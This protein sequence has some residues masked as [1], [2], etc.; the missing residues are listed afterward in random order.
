[1][2]GLRFPAVQTSALLSLLGMGLF[3]W[4][5]VPPV[6]AS[7]TVSLAVEGPG[8]ETVYLSLR[9]PGWLRAGASEKIELRVARADTG[10]G[11][12]RWLTA[13]DLHAAG[14]LVSPA[15][16]QGS[17]IGPSEQVDYRWQVEARTGEGVTLEMSL[18]VQMEETD[19][20]R[21]VWAEASDLPVM[22]YLGMDTATARLAGGLTVTVAAISLA[23]S[24]RLSHFPVEPE[25]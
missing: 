10:R 3:A 18:R 15:S 22:D 23:V 19:V 13:V 7:E 14:A 25:K 6:P 20:E 17:A 24:S 4:T 21:T 1:M 16:A 9:S 11:D 12:G 5:F 8:S 2:P